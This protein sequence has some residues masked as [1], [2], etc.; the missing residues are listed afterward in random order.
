M[1]SEYRLV[2]KTHQCKSE[3]ASQHL[4]RLI[5]SL[6]AAIL[7]NV[8]TGSGYLRV[9]GEVEELIDKA[10]EISQ[11]TPWVRYDIG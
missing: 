10:K 8:C 3:S 11:R 5:E 1:P 4:Q 7:I 6:R 2:A 9:V